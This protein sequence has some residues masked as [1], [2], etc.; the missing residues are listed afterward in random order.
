MAFPGNNI[1]LGTL[2]AR[3]LLAVML[4]VW[5]VIP[6]SAVEEPAPS[7]AIAFLSQPAGS[8]GKLSNPDTPIADD[9]VAGGLLSVGDNNTTGKFLGHSF[10]FEHRILEPGEDA[11][12]AF[13]AVVGHGF[14]FIV[15]NVQ[16]DV[17]LAM[18]DQVR[19]KNVL[20]FNAG[21]RDDL[22]RRKECRSNLFHIA[23]SRA[24]LADGLAQYLVRKR[25][26]DWFLVVGQR[27]GDRR[28]AA[29]MRRAGAKFGARIVAE[30]QWQYGPNVRRSA[31]AEVP[32][33]TQGI[34]Y[35]VL[36][37]ADEIGEFGEY[38]AY[39]TWDPRPIAGS[40][41]LIPT[42]WHPT[43]EQWG[44]AQLQ[45][46]FEKAFGRKMSPLDYHVW[47]A[48]RSVGEAVARTGATEFGKI[49]A[50]LESPEF[51]LAGFKGQKL[52]FRSWN[53]QLRQPILLAAPRALVSVS[54]QPGF[55]HRYSLLDTLGLDRPE[56]ECTLP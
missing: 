33:F 23:P 47:A 9:G 25:W 31:Q 11:L 14:E 4:V 39:R 10:V 1:K 56:V 20:L 52:T 6:A 53:H 27:E 40:Q 49:R 3:A 29:A 55:L 13:D 28:F 15:L 42:S 5:G 17:L 34:A 2:A 41:G 35:D 22:L 51:E 7:L 26:R 37:V 32:R 48:V 44:A 12:A 24:M 8:Q 38:L 18:A 19:E 54:P 43:H 30:K 46:R 21:A 16:S 50:Y 36:V 45:G